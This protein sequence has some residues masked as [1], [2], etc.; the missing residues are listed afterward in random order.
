[1]KKVLFG[2]LFVSTSVFASD[3]INLSVDQKDKLN[4][5][6][7]NTVHRINLGRKFDNGLVLEGRMEDETVH[8]PSKQ[9][10]LMQIKVE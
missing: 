9:E 5:N 1:M 4:S 7:V 6:Q 3:Y 2:L 10:G 8:N